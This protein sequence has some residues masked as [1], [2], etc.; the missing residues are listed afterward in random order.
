MV[1]QVHLWRWEWE[2]VWAE[3]PWGVDIDLLTDREGSVVTITVRITIIFHE[4][5]QLIVAFR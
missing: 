2:M 3:G 5:Y 4:I 1:A